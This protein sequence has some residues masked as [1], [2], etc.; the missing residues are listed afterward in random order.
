MLW[1]SYHTILNKKDIFEQ[2]N[3]GVYLKMYSYHAILDK[4]HILFKQNVFLEK[5]EK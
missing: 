5:N 2:F 1:Y 4:K 3:E